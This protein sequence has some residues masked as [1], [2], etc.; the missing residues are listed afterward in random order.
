MASC[1]EAA[2][3]LRKMQM[4]S[5]SDGKSFEQTNELLGMAVAT[6]RKLYEEVHMCKSFANKF[7]KKPEQQTQ[8]HMGIAGDDGIRLMQALYCAVY[9]LSDED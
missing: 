9:W 2:G 6:T 3:P 4:L 1:E 8:A 5:D 7:K